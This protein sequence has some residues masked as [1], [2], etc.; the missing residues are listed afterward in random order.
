MRATFRHTAYL[1]IGPLLSFCI[2][3]AIIIVGIWKHQDAIDWWKMRGYVPTAS[4]RQVTTD[5]TMTTY[6]RHLFY[7]NRPQLQ[8][9]TDF[10]INC[11][12][13]AEKTI[14][15][16]C[17][18]DGDSGI[19]L[20]NVTDT[21]LTGVVQTTAAH[22]MLHAAYAR[23]D[24]KTRTRIDQLLNDYYAHSLKDARVKE[25]V[26]QYKTLEPGQ[27]T[28]EMHSIFAT[29]VSSLTPEL[30][31]YY[32]RYFTNRQTVVAFSAQYEQEFTSR[33]EQ[34]ARYDEQLS[35]LGKT[36]DTN[37]S[38]LK[39]R[40]TDLEKQYADL[41]ARR[42]SADPTAY[43]AS[44]EQYNVLLETTKTDIADYNT[45]V[46]KRN[47]LALEERNLVQSLTSSPVA[48]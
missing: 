4:V 27:L 34:A 21:R 39:T 38:L 22:E 5:T 14:I 20:Y 30:E 15:L 41:S 12:F 44:V 9:G 16:G 45:I 3:G 42:Q 36:I 43:N 26:D 1:W 31:A 33:R 25:T 46:E 2:F 23:L 17:Y 18:H 13:G 29:E 40:R 48:P 19:F 37:E 10:E 28:N 47:A 8:T 7:V 32:S 35:T 24:T 11:N 6:G